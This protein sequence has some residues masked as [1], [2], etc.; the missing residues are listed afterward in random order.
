VERERKKKGWVFWGCFSG[1]VAKGPRIF[2][3]KDWGP[4]NG[5][6]YQAPTVAVIYGW[7]RLHPGHIFMQD[8]APGHTKKETIEDLIDR[9]IQRIIWPP[10]SPDL[11]PI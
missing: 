7:M 11:N 8:G 10:F 2:W 4:I 6:S 3:E 9:G 5:D 1:K